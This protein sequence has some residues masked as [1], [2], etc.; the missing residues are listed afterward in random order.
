MNGENV[1]SNGSSVECAGAVRSIEGIRRLQVGC[2]PDHIR[3]GWWNVDILG[4][5]GID[6]VMDVTHP[7]PWIDFL[8]YVYGEHFIEH[9]EIDG[10]IKFLLEAGKALRP[11]GSIR[12]STPSLEWVTL[13][14]FKADEADSDQSVRQT[15]AIN[16]AFHGWGHRFL[17]SK[18]MLSRLLSEMGYEDVEFYGYGES[19]NSDLAGL[20][21]HPGYKITSGYPSVWIVQAKR[22]QIRIAASNEFL[23]LIHQEFGRYVQG[24]H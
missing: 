2:G 4:F 7:W 6:Q 1:E 17:Y 24:G 20:E 23:K 15:L 5:K 22:G 19:N 13:T 3:P 11:G 16:R 14:H 12:L 9:L 18:P 10:A 8:Y 21:L